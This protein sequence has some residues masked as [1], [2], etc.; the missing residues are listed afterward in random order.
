MQFSF[1]IFCANIFI[2]TTRC[3]GEEGN[4][5]YDMAKDK[6]LLSSNVPRYDTFNFVR[7]NGQ[8]IPENV[9]QKLVK[10]ASE[11]LNRKNK[12]NEKR[13]YHGSLGNY[14]AGR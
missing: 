10:L 1:V 12:R 13:A 4:V 7:S 2:V 6:H 8:K 3:H 11:I 5:V 9:S 14:F